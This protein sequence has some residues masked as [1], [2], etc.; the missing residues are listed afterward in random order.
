MTQTS[1]PVVTLKKN[2]APAV[3]S[4][5]PKPAESISP[6]GSSPKPKPCIT[7]DFNRIR[8]VN[9]LRLAPFETYKR[10]GSASD[11]NTGSAPG[12]GGQRTKPVA[13]QRLA[14]FF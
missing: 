8:S 3:S 11:G 4:P 12:D 6:T 13:K 7:E 2:A 5:K 10:T 14:G 1:E 9:S